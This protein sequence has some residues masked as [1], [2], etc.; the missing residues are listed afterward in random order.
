[1]ADPKHANGDNT[2]VT[3]MVVA[4]LLIVGGGG[5]F[6]YRR[7][8]IR[9]EMAQQQKIERKE[10]RKE[11]REQARKKDLAEDQR[12]LESM[13]QEQLADRGREAR[14][15]QDLADAE[16]DALRQAQ[17]SAPRIFGH[18]VP[19][20][21]ATPEDLYARWYALHQNAKRTSTDVTGKQLFELFEQ[22]ARV[23]VLAI[24]E[25][26][27]RRLEGSGTSAAPDSETLCYRALGEA[28]KAR[29]EKLAFHSYRLSNVQVEGDSAQLGVRMVGSNLQLFELSAVREGENT[30]RFVATEELLPRTEDVFPTTP[31][32]TPDKAAKANTPKAAFEG[33]R[34]AVIAGDGWTVYRLSSEDAREMYWSQ[35]RKLG[36]EVTEAEMV[37]VITKTLRDNRT[38]RAGYA[39]LHLTRVAPGAGDDHAQLVLRTRTGREASVWARRDSEGWRLDLGPDRIDELA[40]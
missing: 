11:A 5:F 19:D 39:G 16:A 29:A 18:A 35:V 38:V 24:F 34:R 32:P 8:A 20:S 1:M 2:T 4:A 36:M 15:R 7:S 22:S 17:K 10:A 9:E 28:A 30:W 6:A 37:A 27:F 21:V 31:R 13:R 3:V 12:L 33:F 40:R 14:L 23:E 25:A 26:A